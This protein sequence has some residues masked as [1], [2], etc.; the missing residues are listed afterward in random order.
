[1][2]LKQKMFHSFYHLGNYKGFRSS[3]RGTMEKTEYILK[4]TTSQ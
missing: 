1:M 2:P 4:I 3:V